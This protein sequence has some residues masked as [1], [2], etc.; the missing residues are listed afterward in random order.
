MKFLQATPFYKSYLESFYKRNQCLQNASLIET[1]N[2]LIM[3]GF[4]AIHINAQYM[5][6]Y[7]YD[8]GLLIT[9]DIVSQS[10]WLKEKN[11]SCEMGNDW[12]KTVLRMQIEMLKPDVLYLLDPVTYDSS[13]IRTLSWQPEL[14]VGWRAANIPEKTDWSE[15][16]VILSGLA[17]I[18][19]TALDLGARFVENFVP[20]F[21]KWILSQIPF[22][23]PVYDVA[24]SGSWTTAQHKKR[25]F[26]L[27]EIAKASRSMDRPFS[28]GYYLNC[29]RDVLTPDVQA[30]N[31]GPRFGIDMY[32]S[33]RSGR[34]A[35]DARGDIELKNDTGGSATDMAR[36]ETMNMRIFEATGCGSFLLTEY[37][38][39]LKDYFEIGKEIEVF[40]DEKELVDK[41]RYYLD[42]RQQREEIAKKGQERCLK[43]Y[44]MTVRVAEFD[45]L[46]RK[47]IE[48]KQKVNFNI[49]IPTE[50][51]DINSGLMN[52]K[53][54]QEESSENS[55]KKFY[56]DVHFGKSVQIIGISNTEIGKGSAIGDDTWINIANRDSEVRI[57]IGENTLIGRRATIS[58]HGYVEI[59]NHG[60]WAPNVYVSEAN[61]VFA[62]IT[63]PITEQGTTGGRL[64]VEENCWLGIN[65]VVCGDI[66]VGRG[67]VVGA[68]SVVLKDVPAFS[69]VA[70]NPARIIKMYNP[71]S[72][73]WEKVFGNEDV[74]RIEEIR[75]R[76][77]IPSRQEYRSMLDATSGGKKVNPIVVGN[78]IS[79]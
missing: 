28:C 71:Q 31:L 37:F 69:V 33:L 45:R 74:C 53:I 61:H 44:S 25:N 29:G 75:C 48:L 72:G 64:I 58:A 39:N 8:S 46:I 22:E 30:Y 20:G 70:G 60:L 63:R 12:E 34:I 76:F 42:H 36:N 35:I 56:P 65:S 4:G 54:T 38:D 68:N 62:D 15:F 40:R 18:R 13:F 77:G 23:E 79:I 19:K 1:I 10:K 50:A 21:P 9:N 11:I 51:K 43:D 52:E 27:N 7:G 16:D 41:I 17:G 67:S 24:F 78:G 6:E 2:A 3:S 66:N 57:R 49:P 14:V 26:Y 73:L 55:I 59:G 47:H 32:S 5:S